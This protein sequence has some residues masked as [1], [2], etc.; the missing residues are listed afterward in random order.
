MSNEQV[1]IDKK[2]VAEAIKNFPEY[3]KRQQEYCRNTKTQREIL[4]C[5]TKRQ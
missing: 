2:I 3:H 4:R 5:L 1:E